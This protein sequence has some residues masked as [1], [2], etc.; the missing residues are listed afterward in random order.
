MSRKARQRKES[1]E[2]ERLGLPPDAPLPAAAPP[3]QSAPAPDPDRWGAFPWQWRVDGAWLLAL[4]AAAFLLFA[5]SLGNGFVYDDIPYIFENTRLDNWRDAGSFFR[6]TYTGEK[7]DGHYRPLTLWSWAIER[8]LFGNVPFPVHLTNV[9]L[10]AVCAAL[11][12]AFLALLLEDRRLAAVAA[13]LWAA[14]PVHTEVVANGVG[15]SEL[16]AMMFMLAAAVAHLVALR[17]ADDWK[18]SLPWLAAGMAGYFAALLFKE[19][20][21]TLPGLLFLAE[22]IVIRRMKISEDFVV[23]VWRYV[24]Y[25]VPLGIYLAMRASVIEVAAPAQQEVMFGQPKSVVFLYGNETLLRYLG[26]LAAPLH[27]SAEYSDYLNP[28]R[29]NLTDP[30]VAAAFVAW[31]VIGAG[32]WLLARRG[33]RLPAFGAAWFF[34]GILPVSNIVIQIGTVRADRLLFM[35]S[36]GFAVVAA[37]FFLRAL[38]PLRQGAYALLAVY[39]AFYCWRTFD[40][41]TVWKTRDSLWT[42]TIAS[43]PG[44]AV[45]WGFVGDIAR[46]RGD[47]AEAF[48]HYTRAFE[49]RERLGFFYREANNHRASMLVKQGKDAE[50]L[51]LYLLSTRKVPDNHVAFVNG[52]EILLRTPDRRAE[53]VPLLERAA[54]LQPNDL[55][56]NVNLAQAYR[57]SGRLEDAWQRILIAERLQPQNAAVKQVKTELEALRGR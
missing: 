45:G 10:N 44:S 21:V 55:A 9:L 34:L 27:L 47:F 13:A 16:G 36:L 39:L 49:L 23:G 5:N 57:F 56:V 8:G 37:W 46:D 28:V 19:T 12:Y 25:A 24:A 54:Q 11:V 32:A 35:P 31:A 18:R 52:A 3:D 15:R 42:A 1:L 2:R 51:E 22:L 30:M 40:R 48:D 43:N 6:D 14:H 29:S 33:E 53:A 20:P 7:T 26:Q 41:N 4:A 17:R 50:A 38:R